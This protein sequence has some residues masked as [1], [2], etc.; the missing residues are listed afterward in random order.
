MNQA[1]QIHHSH[2][3]GFRVP[4][5]IDCVTVV[6]DVTTVVS[7]RD[8]EKES[9]L[10]IIGHLFRGH[11]GFHQWEYVFQPFASEVPDLSQRV[12]VDF[13]RLHV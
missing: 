12:V 1:S 6:K 5:I 8:I 10:D 2:F 4:D 13:E 7:S 3:I 9:L 11:M